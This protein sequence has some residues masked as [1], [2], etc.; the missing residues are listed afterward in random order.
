MGIK[1]EGPT[2]CGTVG[3]KPRTPAPT[4]SPTVRLTVRTNSRRL[5]TLES[6]LWRARVPGVPPAPPRSP[7]TPGSGARAARSPRPS[8]AGA[9]AIAP[10]RARPQ[11]GR[12]HV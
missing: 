1:S 8:A 12:A 3:R 5:T 2:D 6:L 10:T 11:I 9:T 4:D 7:D